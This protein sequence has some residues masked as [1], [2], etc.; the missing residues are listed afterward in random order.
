MTKQLE[1]GEVSAATP[2]PASMIDEWAAWE[3]VLDD[4]GCYE[5]VCGAVRLEAYEDARRGFGWRVRWRSDVLRGKS[6]D[7]DQAKRDAIAVAR[8]L[9]RESLEL[10]DALERDS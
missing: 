10:V 5:A 3:P 8:K 9:L 7:L 4:H 2:A 6:D 1:L